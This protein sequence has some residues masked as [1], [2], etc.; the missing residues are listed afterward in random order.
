MGFIHR[1]KKNSITILPVTVAD[2]VIMNDKDSGNLT[3]HLKKLSDDVDTLKSWFDEDENGHIHTKDGRGFYSDSFVS[4]G[5]VSTDGT[6]GGEGTG[7]GLSVTQMWAELAQKATS[8]SQ[9]IHDSHIP[10]TVMR[11]TDMGDFLTKEDLMW[12]NITD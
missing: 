4:A 6:E 7:G 8:T 3:E 9:I 5:G 2:A 10:D 12:K 11:K 1:L